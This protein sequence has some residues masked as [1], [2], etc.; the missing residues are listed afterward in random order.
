[1]V[2][3]CSHSALPDIVVVFA[4]FTAAAA[5]VA[6]SSEMRNE[7]SSS[8]LTI[9]SA[10]APRPPARACSFVPVHS[11]YLRARRA[12]R[13][14]SPSRQNLTLNISVRVQQRQT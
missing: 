3:L 11:L 12:G 14:L 13:C 1:M 7:D 8:R 5:D 4:P 10:T 9:A 6:P 2:E